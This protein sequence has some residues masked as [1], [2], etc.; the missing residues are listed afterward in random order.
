MGWPALLGAFRFVIVNWMWLRRAHRL[1]AGT[2]SSAV[3]GAD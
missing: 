2:V 3:L 1:F